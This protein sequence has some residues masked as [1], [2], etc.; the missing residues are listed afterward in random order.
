MIIHIARSLRRREYYRIQAFSTG[1][2]LLHVAM[3]S[4]GSFQRTKTPS[5]PERRNGMLID[6]MIAD[7]NFGG[8]QSVTDPEQILLSE[9]LRTDRNRVDFRGVF[10]SR[11]VYGSA[12]TKD[13]AF[14][15][16]MA[17]AM[18]QNTGRTIQQIRATELLAH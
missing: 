2:S 10:R 9:I 17:S 16:K 3:I 15:K 5:E 1:F 18:K 6:S 7:L 12:W 11:I 14:A 8:S 13:E 4:I